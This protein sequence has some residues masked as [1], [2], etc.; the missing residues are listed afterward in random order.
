MAYYISGFDWSV[1]PNAAI[2]R[3]GAK[4]SEDTLIVELS[5]PRYNSSE[6][7]LIYTTKVLNNYRGDKLAEFVAKADPALPRDLGTVSIFID[8]S[9]VLTC[10]NGYVRCPKGECAPN[11]ITCPS[12]VACPQGTVLCSD[13]ACINFRAECTLANEC[14]LHSPVRCPDGK[15][16]VSTSLCPQIPG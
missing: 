14:P 5:D 15:C 7:R 4:E 6:R 16:A 2:S 1:P 9:S 8:S 10:P 12:H 11:L 13:G 3:P